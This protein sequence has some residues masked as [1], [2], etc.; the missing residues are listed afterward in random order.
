MLTRFQRGV[1]SI[2]AMEAD[3]LANSRCAAAPLR[4]GP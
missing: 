3:L 4:G 2:D 1:L